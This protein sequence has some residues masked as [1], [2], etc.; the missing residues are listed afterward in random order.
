MDGLG[1]TYQSFPRLYSNEPLVAGG[2]I[3]LD[4][5][6]SHYLRH[7]LRQDIGQ[8]V[9]VFNGRDGEW[10]VEIVELGKKHGAARVVT[11]L[12]A[13]GAEPDIWLCF[14][15]IKHGRIDYL[16]Q[17]AT[18]LGAS[19]LQP[20][21]TKHTMVSRVNVERLRANVVEAAEQCE[22]LSVPE[23]REPLALDK[24]LAKWPNERRLIFCDESGEGRPIRDVLQE[25]SADG[26]ILS[27]SLVGP[28]GGFAPSEQEMI[29]RQ[30][31]CDPV[32]LGPR[33]LRADTAAVAVLTAMQM[34]VGDWNFPPRFI[35]SE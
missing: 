1:S 20:V 32:A 25:I 8:N 2:N 21:I 28:E 29:R 24:L 10:L 19:V 14:A 26:G 23:V 15:P 6:Q 34:Y 18:E 17:K 11:R 3:A 9:R 12:R 22:R 5:N 33:V 4:A 16:V 30:S 35:A 31:Y 27:A 7:V 13:Q